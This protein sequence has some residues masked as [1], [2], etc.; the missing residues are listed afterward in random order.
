MRISAETRAR[1]AFQE[2]LKPTR[3]RRGRP[4]T[5]WTTVIQEDLKEAGISIKLKT[6]DAIP[7]LEQLCSMRDKFKL[8]TR[9]KCH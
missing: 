6:T 8:K 9:P 7:K 5:T 3:R 1:K 4:L 2:S